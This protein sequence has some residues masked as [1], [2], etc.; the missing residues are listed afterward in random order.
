MGQPALEAGDL[1]IVDLPSPLLGLV[2]RYNEQELLCLFNFSSAAIDTEL[3]MFSDFVP[4]WGLGF[5]FEWDAAPR[6]LRLPAWGV[7]FADLRSTEAMR[8]P[9]EAPA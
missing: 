8:S 5:D 6:R 3:T 9:H 2:R 7:F 1:R 4:A